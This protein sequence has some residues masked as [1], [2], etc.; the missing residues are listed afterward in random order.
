MMTS[1]LSHSA[2]IFSQVWQ[3]VSDAIVMTD[4]ART[5]LQA[6]SAYPYA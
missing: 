3:H 2:Q 5:I 1:L 6:N 4:Q